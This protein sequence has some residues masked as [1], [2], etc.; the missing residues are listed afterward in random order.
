MA[1]PC[2][3]CA[4][5]ERAAIDDALRIGSSLDKVVTTFGL[6]SRSALQRH[7]ATH[8][9]R[10]VTLHMPPSA[11]HAAPAVSLPTDAVDDAVEAE[12]SRMLAR[13]QQAAPPSLQL[14][15]RVAVDELLRVIAAARLVQDRDLMVRALRE[16]RGLIALHASV[17]PERMRESVGWEPPQ[18]RP[19]PIDAMMRLLMGPIVGMD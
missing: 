9:G 18:P 6:P 19:N 17:A 10:A 4:H 15:A 11:G 12:L 8:L 5:P 3:I 16:L 14:V 7:R 2:S 13:V 1:R